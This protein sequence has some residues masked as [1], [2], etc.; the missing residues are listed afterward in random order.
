MKSVLMIA[1]GF[2]PEGNAGVYRPLRFVR[3]LPS[4]GWHPTV[5]TLDAD[6][7][8]RYDPFLLS[9][10]PKEIEVIRVRN[11]DPWQA[12]QARRSERIQNQLGRGATEQTIRTLSARQNPMR[13]RARELVRSIEARV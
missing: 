10:V 7:F 8:E 1:Y 4:F 5:I 12:F 2:P 6:V 3:H 13:S 9:Q 11:R